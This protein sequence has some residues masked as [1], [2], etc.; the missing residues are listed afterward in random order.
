MKRATAV[1]IGILLVMAIGFMV[2]QQANQNLPNALPQS[3][4]SYGQGVYYA[5]SYNYQTNVYSGGAAAA[6][7]Y[8]ITVFKPGITLADGRIFNPFSTAVALTIGQGANQETVTPSSVANCGITAFPVGS[9][10][11]TITAT[12]TL[13]HGQ[14]D[15]IQSSTSGLAE[16]TSDAGLH[17][18]GLVFFNSDGG[19]V[20]LATGGATTTVC[21]N[22]IPLNG[23]VLG[24]VARITTTITSCTGGWE[25]GDGT[26]ATRFTGANATLTAGTVSAAD[27]QTTSGVASTTT[28]M[29]NITSVKSIVNT[30]VTSNAGAGAMHVRAFGYVLATPNQ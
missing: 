9:A 30:C 29:L 13:G 24:V 3:F 15:L 11:C 22:C 4:E 14:G 23:I 6:G 2:A 12:F 8:S 18:G 5:P 10:L 28:G 26:T 17:G 1:V 19:I 25:L 27:L 20:T 7:T 16:A 21:T